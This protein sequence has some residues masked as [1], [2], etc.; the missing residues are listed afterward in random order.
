MD[1]ITVE[2]IALAGYAG[3]GKSTVARAAAAELS[4]TG[5]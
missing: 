2:R 3:S 4:R 1:L 5:T